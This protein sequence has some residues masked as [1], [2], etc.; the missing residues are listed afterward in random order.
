MIWPRFIRYQLDNALRKHMHSTCSSNNRWESSDICLVFPCLCVATVQQG[1]LESQLQVITVKRAWFVA[2][3]AFEVT[4]IAYSACVYESEMYPNRSLALSAHRVVV[5]HSMLLYCLCSSVATK[6]A[7]ALSQGILSGDI[8][9]TARFC[10]Y[11]CIKCS[12]FPL[13]EQYRLFE[14]LSMGVNKVA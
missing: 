5:I 13:T 14:A 4:Y 1:T 9:K 8:N 6:S 7:L 10:L 2:A 12:N 11:S 3:A